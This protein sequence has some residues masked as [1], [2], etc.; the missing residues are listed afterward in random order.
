MAED[1]HQAAGNES[2]ASDSGEKKKSTL[3]SVIGE[4]GSFAKKALTI[5]AIAAMP[6]AYGA[7]DSS[8]IRLAA[9][10]TTGFAAG[11][12]TANVIQKKGTLDGVVA[13]GFR[14]NVISAPLAFGFNALN[15][16]EQTVA[17]SYGFAAS[18]VAKAGG[19]A[20]VQQP[21]IATMNTALEYGIGKKFRENWLPNI[22]TAV[23]YIAIPGI[24]NVTYLYQFGI[25][26]QMAASA[27]ISYIFNLTQALRHGEGSFRNLTSALNPFSYITAGTKATYKL[28]RNTTKGI[29]EAIYSIGGAV[30]SYISLATKSAPKE[31]SPAAPAHPEP[32]S[33]H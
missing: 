15:E 19:L 16:L 24:I 22:K 18:K 29:G 1:N 26:V 10:T 21:A 31:S 11:K 32:A 23:K 9:T 27:T 14:G 8:H 20:L 33:A 3:E 28:I 7:F 12:A 13:A 5:G 2:H 25:F 6:F 4:L 30:G 17:S